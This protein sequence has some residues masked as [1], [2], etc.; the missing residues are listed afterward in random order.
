MGSWSWNGTR[1]PVPTFTVLLHPVCW[2]LWKAGGQICMRCPMTH[3]LGSRS[4]VGICLCFLMLCYCA[5]LAFHA[6]LNTG[7]VHQGCLS[8]N[9]GE[10]QVPPSLNTRRPVRSFREVTSGSRQEPPIVRL[11]GFAGA[12]CWRLASEITVQATP[13]A[14]ETRAPGKRRRVPFP[15]STSNNSLQASIQA[16]ASI[17][18]CSPRRNPRC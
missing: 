18:T 8:G 7:G 14:F 6:T 11:R 4:Q 12:R 9:Q 2:A 5:D 15:V 1:L 3:P 16:T 10:L 17:A 13:I